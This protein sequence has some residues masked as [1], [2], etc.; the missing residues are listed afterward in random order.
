MARTPLWLKVAAG[1]VL[2]VGL[3]VLPTRLL[4]EGW[5]RG[6]HPFSERWFVGALAFLVNFVVIAWCWEIGQARPGVGARP[7]AFRV[8]SLTFAVLIAVLA[9]HTYAKTW[10]FRAEGEASA[11]DTLVTACGL[12]GA[13]AGALLGLLARARFGSASTA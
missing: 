12:G 9:G 4:W 7:V 13:A 5:L 1:L 2:V 10:A 8:A 6:W 3:V 11:I